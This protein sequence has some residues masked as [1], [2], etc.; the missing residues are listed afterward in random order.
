MLRSVACVGSSRRWFQPR[1]YQ[2]A[3]V[4][5]K[6]SPFM[7]FYS[8]LLHHFELT[9][10]TYS[11]TPNLPFPQTQMSAVDKCSNATSSCLCLCVKVREFSSNYRLGPH[12]C[13]QHACTHRQNIT[14][15]MHTA[16]NFDWCQPQWPKHAFQYALHTRTLNTFQL[17]FGTN[18]W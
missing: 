4:I 16:S 6:V 13:V 11:E 10:K 18:S 3:Q 8:S 9:F 14:L 12:K 5:N 2:S 15:T 17:L 7:S 1:L